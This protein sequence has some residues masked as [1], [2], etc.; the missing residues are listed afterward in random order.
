M[1]YYIL[2]GLHAGAVAIWI[3]GILLATL[4]IY[5]DSVSTKKD[6]PAGQRLGFVRSWNRWVT[7]P[8][9]LAVWALGIAMTMQ[10]GWY[11]FIWF[12]LKIVLVLLLS[13][14]HGKLTAT[15]RRIGNGTITSVPNGIQ[16]FIAPIT[17]VS[18]IAIIVLV[19]AKPFGV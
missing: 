2:L 15:L 6:I 5:I 14:V 9:M 1:E 13:A 11:M 8:A 18:T 19:I 10:I 3:G 16:R 17:I 7:T 12:K 4:A